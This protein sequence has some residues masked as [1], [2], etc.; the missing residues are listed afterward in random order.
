[1]ADRLIER[2][3]HEIVR[4]GAD[5]LVETTLQNI[6]SDA[7]HRPAVTPTKRPRAQTPPVPNGGMSKSAQKKARQRAGRTKAAADQKAEISR[8]QAALT[9]RGK[10]PDPVNRGGGTPAKRIRAD[11]GSPKPRQKM[12]EAEF[13][14]LREIKAKEKNGK[15]A[16]RFWN[17]SIG[18][19]AQEG[20]CQFAHNLCILCGA[21]HKWIDHHHSGGR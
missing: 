20:Q 2:T 18:C 7:S 13:R 4:Q 8:L 3:L 21:N 16:C 6:S 1:M 5:N 17:S 9:N 19:S 14:A 15:R 10:H 11:A 12:P